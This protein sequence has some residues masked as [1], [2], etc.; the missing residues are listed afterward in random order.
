MKGENG[1]FMEN[2]FTSEKKFG[3]GLMRLPLLNPNDGSSIDIEL[4]KKMVDT[5]LEKG[6][7]YFDTAWMYCG[8]KSENAAKEALVSRHPRESY[9]LATKLH[10]GFIKTLED[11]DKVFNE[12]REKTG[13]T[14]FDYYLLHDVG[15]DHYE[16]YKK[17][18][19]FNWLADKKKHG[20]VK[21]M[22]FSFHDNAELLDK[23]LT[24]HPEMEFV[25]LQINY[26]DW[27][28]EAI[29]SRKCYEVAT[30]H[31]KPVIVMEPVKG[32]TL[33]NVPKKVEEAF[34]AY[35]KEMSIPSWAIR[36]VAS[37]PNVKMVL[38]GMSNMEQLLDNTGYMQDFKPLND[39]E[40][41]IVKDTSLSTIEKIRHILGVMPESYKEIDFE[42]L[43]LLKDKYP[44]IYRK[45]E[46][47]LESGW[48]TT[49]GLLEQGMNEGVIRHVNLT[50]F[51]MM[52]EASLEQ[53]F[54]R[55]ILVR[56][57][58]TYAQGLNEVVS[59][60]LNGIEEAD[61]GR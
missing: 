18:D 14:Y 16:V 51:K 29:Q 53:F 15:V 6:F 60:L 26:L 3:F 11:R 44:D 25:Q 57:D 37:L 32:G 43:Y 49:L 7:T 31:G 20:L 52:M 1:D 61:Y 40:Q 8:F 35:N 56:A 5:F 46:K 30:K 36:F 27:D 24:E 19:C 4:T 17:L 21:H 13:V 54:Q 45:V 23:V 42:Q 55:D 50:V 22:G 10:A 9:T 34:K 28:S 39:E 12:Q 38:S 59:I 48:E 41:K 58:M 47:R 33:A 2:V